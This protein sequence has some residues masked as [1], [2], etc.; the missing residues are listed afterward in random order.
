[1]G[2]IGAMSA[3]GSIPSRGTRENRDRHCVNPPLSVGYRC[4]ARTS[5]AFNYE[6]TSQRGD[7]AKLILGRI[8]RIRRRAS[9]NRRLLAGLQLS[10]VGDAL[11]FLQSA[12]AGASA[13]ETHQGAS[14][15]PLGLRSGPEFYSCPS[16]S[17]Y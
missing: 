10:L 17:D 13:S 9:Q 8:A 7:I 3:S 4:V 6:P 15:R 16:Q 12:A 14:D 1:M 5:Q 2:I 11:S